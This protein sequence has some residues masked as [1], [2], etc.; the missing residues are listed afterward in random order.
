MTA[1]QRRNFLKKAALGLSA[2]AISPVHSMAAERS[3]AEDYKRVGKPT[4]IS[5][6]QTTNVNFQIHAHDEL[7]WENDK[8]VFRKTG[9]YPQMA[10]MLNDFRKKCTNLRD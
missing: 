7:F 8:A 4:I 9:G 2:A 10:S 1:E 3:H 6:L 5:I